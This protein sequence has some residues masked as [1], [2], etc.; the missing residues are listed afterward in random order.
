MLTILES[1]LF[2]HLFMVNDFAP[3]IS[4]VVKTNHVGSVFE[5]LASADGSHG[6][7]NN[8]CQYWNLPFSNSQSV[9]GE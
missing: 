9:H 5:I 7:D 8:K 4:P 1:P 2:E 6:M 3:P